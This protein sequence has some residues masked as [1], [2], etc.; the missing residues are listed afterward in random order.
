MAMS[1][2]KRWIYVFVFAASILLATLEQLYCQPQVM[3]WGN[4]TG[5]RVDGH[6]FEFETSLCVIGPSL[7]QVSQTA[8]EQQRPQYR[9]E[10]NKQTINTRLD[11]IS[12]VEE[13]ES[14]G[15][16]QA[17]VSVEAEARA[18]TSISGVFLCLE[19]SANEFSDAEI[20]LVD[21]MA[22]KLDPI[23]LFP[24]RRWG[25]MGRNS[26][27]LARGVR[28]K[29]PHRRIEIDVDEPAEIIRTMGNRF[30]GNSNTRIYFG[31][32]PGAVTNGKTGKKSFL[33]KVSGEIDKRPVQLVVDTKNP[34][35]RFDGIGG[36]F[37]LQNE[38]T[39]AQVIDYCLKNLN[40][41]WGR[42]EMPWRSWHAEENVD[43]IQAARSGRLNPGVHAAMSMA[44]RLAKKNIPVIVSAWYP[45]SWAVEGEMSFRS[46][47][48]LRGNPL[49]RSK[50]QSIIKSLTGY[51]LYLKEA[52]GVEASLFSFNESD[53]GINVRQTGE[54]H[55]ELIQKLGENMANYGLATKMLLGDNSDATTYSF[56]EPAMENPAIHKHIG[57]ISFHTWRG[58]E[59]WTLSIWADAAKKLNVPL[60]VGEG[61]TDAAAHRYP[62]IFL[63]PAYALNE[64]DMY[65]R[66]CAI[67]QV[68]SIL[69]WQLTS[70]YSVLAG[71]GIYHTTGELR[72][73]QR[74]WNLKQLGLTPS[75]SF[76]L[77]ISGSRPNI[78]CVAY[79]DI[80]KGVY[81]IHMVNNGARRQVMLNGLPGQ[82]SHLR[83]FTTDQNHS[84][85]EGKR[86]RV[87]NGVAEFWLESA[88]FTT[89]MGESGE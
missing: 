37:R 75:G 62:D 79:A 11:N 13:V 17:R 8:K 69:Q 56:I 12:I 40:V 4:M 57:A 25:R 87:S 81:C 1:Y 63:Q 34:G 10:G 45:P 22:S 52:Y 46:Q 82:V 9:L 76:V 6:L 85:E 59:N 30:F 3:A 51:L 32:L 83:I 80:A 70:D 29:T 66:I 74:F 58:C 54:E 24:G 42:V 65:L 28:I 88:C 27:A 49:K 16:G 26:Q 5:L 78:S 50:K 60:L 71:N 35:R 55:A 18:D 36:N 89:L 19:L 67:C 73:T 39:D 47:G 77:H 20:L 15:S 72:P 31:V 7:M 53:L 64:I 23:P 61:S 21:S 14:L 33:I 41:T 84:M 38:N 86:V 48:G 44:Q 2:W 43:P 68:K